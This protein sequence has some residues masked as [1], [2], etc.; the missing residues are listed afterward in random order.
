MKKNVTIKYEKALKIYFSIIFNN[1]QSFL[2]NFQ[3]TIY[4]ID[5]TADDEIMENANNI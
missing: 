4:R 5:V 1:N 2:Y 3:Y